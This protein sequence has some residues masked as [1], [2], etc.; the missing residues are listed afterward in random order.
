[1]FSCALTFLVGVS[2]RA[3]GSSHQGGRKVGTM[4]ERDGNDAGSFLVP[5]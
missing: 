1:M 3:E 5:V 2:L 4:A